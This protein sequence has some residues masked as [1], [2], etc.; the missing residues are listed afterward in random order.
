MSE[1]T[2]KDN[3]ESRPAY[4]MGTLGALEEMMRKQ[5]SHADS[6]S[7]NMPENPVESQ[8][9]Q[10]QT[11]SGK[12]LKVEMSEFGYPIID[13][14]QT[15]P[16]DA[17]DFLRFIA[18]QQE[19]VY[20]GMHDNEFRR[21]AGMPD[22]APWET[23]DPSLSH[24]PE[25]RKAVY[26]TKSLEGGIAHAAIEHKTSDINDGETYS[27]KM[28]SI[29]SRIVEVSPQLHERIQEGGEVFTE[30]LLYVL[31]A[32]PFHDTKDSNHEV[33]TQKKV[34]PVLVVKIGGSLGRSVIT[35]ESTEV[36]GGK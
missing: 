22:V 11:E 31:P 15:P 35:P 9:Q 1:P 24:Q 5:Q 4:E 36:R 34:R 19:V 16:E 3:N 8:I 29:G 14:S 33:K 28:N 25:G 23:L 18:S 13:L 27:L 6:E 26:A 21:Q 7:E 12:E 32:E 17:M 10:W 2:P 30:G 20:P